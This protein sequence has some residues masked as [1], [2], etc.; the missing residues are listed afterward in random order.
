MNS[1]YKVKNILFLVAIFI[2]LYSCTKDFEFDKISTENLSGEW[3]FPLINASITLEDVLN[4][5][6]GIITTNEDGFIT[7]VYES[8][9][10]VSMDGSERTK[11]PDQQKILSENLILEDT[12]NYLPPGIALPPL[13]LDPFEFQFEMVDENHRIDRMYLRDGEYI[14]GFTTNM[15]RDNAIVILSIDNFVHVD[16]GEP[17]TVT[18]NLDNPDEE[19]ITRTTVIDLTK[20]YVQFDNAVQQNKVEIKAVIELTTDDNPIYSSYYFDLNNEFNNIKFSEFHG[21]I[22][23][24]VETYTDVVDIS[25][26][27]ATDFSTIQFGEGSVKLNLDVYNSL[28][29]PMTLDVSQLK[30]YN[31]VDVTDSIDLS[32]DPSIIEISYPDPVEFPDYVLTEINTDNIN[33]NEIIAISPDKLLIQITGILNDG[34]PP[35]TPNYFNYNSN[36]YVDASLEFQLFAGISS[37]E[38]VDTLDFDPA[39][40]DGF[41][42]VEFMVEVTNGF[43]INAEIQLTFIDE[44]YT[45][46]LDLFP[47]S[48]NLVEAGNIDPSTDFRVTSPTVKKTFVA[49]DRE[50]LD[51]IEQ[52]TKIYF[53]AILSTDNSQ[54]VKIYDSYNI[55]L[56]LGAKVVYIY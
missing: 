39:S 41:D 19:I 18:F 24:N 12:V 50:G 37:F 27:N 54:L 4:D 8:E 31:T 53:T 55:G 9:N 23:E 35:E 14:I 26:F 38:I 11:I 47:S 33:V 42:T 15:N 32:I 13:D 3:A 22:G 36:L 30:A 1:L 10:L 34:V 20:Y 56:E 43:P 48:E 21:F 51:S 46:L 25:I 17:L 16:S 5:T 7:L 44:N 2:I 6:S 29:L 28:G 40:F 45:P 49:I 52:A